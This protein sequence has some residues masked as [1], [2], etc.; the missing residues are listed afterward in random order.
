MGAKE[1]DCDVYE[2]Y[3][4]TTS[5]MAPKHSKVSKSSK[6]GWGNGKL[7]LHERWK[8]TYAK[9]PDDYDPY[10]DDVREDL[11]EEKVSTYNAIDINL[12]GQSRS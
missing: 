5:F 8:E 11:P 1:T 12:P 4:K 10:D 7:S 9:A 3:N 2:V 6:N